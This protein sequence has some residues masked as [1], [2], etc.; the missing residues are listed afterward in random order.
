MT[1]RRWYSFN[2]LETVKQH[3]SEV[4]TYSDLLQLRY[5]INAADCN[6]TYFNTGVDGVFAVDCVAGE[7][8]YRHIFMTKVAHA[9]FGDPRTEEADCFTVIEEN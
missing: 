9:R 4:K 2:D 3:I 7:N 5:D 1:T 6:L 8:S